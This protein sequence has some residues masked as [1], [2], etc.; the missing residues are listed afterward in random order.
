MKS[1]TLIVLA[2]LFGLSTSAVAQQIP[3]KFI[4]DGAVTAAKLASGVIKTITQETPSGT[5][6][7]SNT[8]FTLAHTPSASATVLL[9]LDGV[10]MLQGTDYTISG[11]SITAT[12]ITPA[13]GQSLRAYYSY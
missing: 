7:G 5:I 12:G 4:A 3:T 9:F 10:L 2:L 8:A 1:K 11:A 6:N 13:T